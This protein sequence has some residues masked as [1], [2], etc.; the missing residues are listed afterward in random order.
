MLWDGLMRVCSFLDEPNIPVRDLPFA[1]AW[2]QLLEYEEQLD[3]PAECKTC[4][5]ARVCLK[6]M[7]AIS[8]KGT[9]Q[10]TN[11]VPCH[12]VQMFARQANE[13][14]QTETKGRND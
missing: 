14:N 11:G 9:E 6:C 8:G 7:A 12:T 3:W 5:A 4:E 10:Q 2:R 13:H 1:E